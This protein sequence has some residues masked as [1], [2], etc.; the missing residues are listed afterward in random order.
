M[1]KAVWLIG[2]IFLVFLGDRSGGWMLHQLIKTSEF[3]YSRLYTGRAECD[4]LLIGNSRGLSFYQ[5]QIEAVTGKQTLNLS[6]NGLPV[7]LAGVLVRDY[8]EG[9]GN[10]ELVVIDITLCD[11]F[12]SEL[13]AQFG[14]YQSSSD[15]LKRLIRDSLNLKSQAFALS[16][17]YRYNSE[18]FQRAIF[19]LN[20]S[21][22][23]WLLD[24]MITDDLIEKVEDENYRFD[25][26]FPDKTPLVLAELTN[27]LQEQGIKVKLIVNPYFPLFRQRM[28]DLDALIAAV[29]EATGLP[30]WDYSTA[31]DDKEAFGD[32]QHLNKKGAKLFIQ[33]LQA[34]KFWDF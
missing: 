10:P 21:D 27:F 8:I 3:R 11:R 6:Y 26:L 4:I 30:V 5:P 17:L 13:T 34:D 1:K 16:H 9:Y 19:Y 24:R 28:T 20:K 12:Y 15:R 32:L 25:L 31:I 14:C 22:E 7:D 23:D 33:K 29:E 18:V 2:F